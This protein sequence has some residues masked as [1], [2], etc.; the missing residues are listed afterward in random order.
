MFKQL[1]VMKSNT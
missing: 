1:M